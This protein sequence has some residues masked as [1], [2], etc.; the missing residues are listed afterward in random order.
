MVF[1]DYAPSPHDYPGASYFLV[2]CCLIVGWFALFLLLALALVHWPWAC[3]HASLF[4]GCLVEHHR[5]VVSGI[6]LALCFYL[7]SCIR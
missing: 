7:L 5:R 3:H 6:I 1:S 4:S 2:F